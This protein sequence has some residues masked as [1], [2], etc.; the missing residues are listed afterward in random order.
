[1]ASSTPAAPEPSEPSPERHV[2]PADLPPHRGPAAMRDAVR[3]LA[4]ERIAPRAA[5]IDRIGR[6][7]VGRQ[8][9][10]RQPRH[11]EPAVPE[12]YGGLG[13]DLL[14][15]CLAVEQISRVCATSGLILAVQELA[16]LPLLLAGTDEPEGALVPGPR[17]RPDA[18]RL[19][20]DGGRGRA[21]TSPRPTRTRATAGDG[22]DWLIDGCEAVHQ[23][24]QRRRPDRGL[25]GHR[26]R[27]R[28]TRRATSG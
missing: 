9:A 2:A 19:R 13:G 4:D 26:R 20:P 7:P 22:D 14:T 11:P 12:A 27:R 24:G 23:P 5:E 21:A 25:R 10:P 6:V 18:D 1:M 3:V 28:R 17:R 8:G 15:V 16:S